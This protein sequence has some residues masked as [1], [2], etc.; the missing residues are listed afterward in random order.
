ML[1]KHNNWTDFYRAKRDE[2]GPFGEVFIKTM[3]VFN[4]TTLNH[5]NAPN[6][7]KLTIVSNTFPFLLVPGPQKTIQLVHNIMLV[8]QAIGEDPVMIC[9]QGNRSSSPSQA[10]PYSAVGTAARG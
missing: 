7:L 2:E 1:L 6:S 4:E 8:P 3:A 10:I 5:L 9:T